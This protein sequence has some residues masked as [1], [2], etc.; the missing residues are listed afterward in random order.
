MPSITNPGGEANGFRVI[1]ASYIAI[2]GFFIKGF[3]YCGIQCGWDGGCACLDI[4]HNILD[5]NGQGGTGQFNSHHTWIEGNIASL[6]GWGSGWASGFDLWRT[7][8]QDNVVW[9]VSPATPA[10]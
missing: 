9:G 3:E 1:N 7:T 5:D 2:H 10:R 4:R 8:G 6:N